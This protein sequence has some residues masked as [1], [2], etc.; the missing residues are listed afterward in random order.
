ML[1][2]ELF[3]LC[4]LVFDKLYWIPPKVQTFVLY[5]LFVWGY[6][7]VFF[8]PFL[9]LASWGIIIAVIFVSETDIWMAN[10]RWMTNMSPC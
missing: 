3:F 2:L 5:N 1:C 8:T 7:I 10:I 6:F 9:F 4:S